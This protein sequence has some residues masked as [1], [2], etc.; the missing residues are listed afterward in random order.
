MASLP[1]CPECA[2]PA[3]WQPNCLPVCPPLLDMPEGQMD[4]PPH[5][6][7]TNKRSSE[8]CAYFYF[9]LCVSFGL[10]VCLSVHLSLLCSWQYLYGDWAHHLA[11]RLSIEKPVQLS[12]CFCV[13]L[14]LSVCVVM[15][16]SA[17]NTCRGS[18]PQ[19]ASTK[20]CR[21]VY[22]V[23]CVSP[24]MCVYKSECLHVSCMPTM[25]EPASWSDLVAA[26][27]SVPATA[28][29][30]WPCWLHLTSIQY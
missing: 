1:C 28:L 10:S 11:L 17:D 15:S 20:A 29:L 27:F 7:F 5:S 9:C 8:N 12:A 6:A 3:C 24:S 26:W 14:S 4:S 25:R 23:F 19:C 30:S 21:L 16:S 22:M 13:S 18:P 2:F